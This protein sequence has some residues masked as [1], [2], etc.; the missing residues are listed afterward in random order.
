MILKRMSAI[1]VSLA[2]VM[3]AVN[4]GSFSVA[5]TAAGTQAVFFVAPDG[6]DSGDGT[7]EAPFATLEKAR[8]EVRKING[9]MTGD[10]VVYLRGGDYR[11]TQPVE[12]DT[13]DSGTG[14]FNVRYEAYDKEVPV[15]NG[16]QQVTG[17]TKYNDKLWS[18]PLDRDIKLRNLYVNDRRANMGSVQVQAK[19]GYGDYHVTAGQ[20]DWAWD[21]GKKSDGIVYD[22]GSMPRITSN[23]DDLEV[24]NGTTWNENI[25]CSRD[26]KYDGG[27]MILLM[28][29]PYGAIAQTPGWGAGFSTGG[30]HTIY[31]AFSFVDSEGEFFFDKTQK[32]LY[33]YPRS[34]EDMTSADVEAPVADGLIKIAGKST[35]DR[36]QN[37]SFSGITFANTDYQL[38][39]VA[40]SHGKTTCQAAQSY[41][42]FADS[43]WHSKKYEMVDT[44][45]AAIHIT[46]SDNIK[47]TGNVVK[48][49]GADGIS[50]T[51]DV[52]NSEV[53]GNFITDITSSGITVGHPQHIYIGDAAWNNH[54]KFPKEVEGICK[55]DLITQN[56]LYDISVV[57]GFGGCAA[58]TAY[59]VESVKILSNT[60]EKT[61]YNGIHLGW[62]WC[63]FKDSTTC[64]DNMICY[65]RV[66]NSLNRL[67]DSGGIYTIGQMPGTVINEN[68]IQG[69][70]AGGPGAPTYGLH[71][72]EGTTYIEENDNVLEIS[73]NVTYTINC[74]EY[75]D[76]HHLTIK[77]T[78][79]TVNKMG[80]NPPY[81]DIDIPIVVSDNV[82]PFAQ[83]KVC[84]NSGISDEYRSLMPTWLKSEADYAFPAS[85]ATTGGSKLPVRKVDGN[86]WI[87]P[88]G[89]TS[90]KAGADMTRA[91]GSAGSIRTPSEEGEYRIY[92][93]DREGK[94]LSKSSHILRIKG[95]GGN[96][97][98]VIEAENYD[99]KSG[100]DIENCSEGGSDVGYIE[101]GDYIGFKDID[102]T[103]ADKIDF[104][105]ASNG[106]DA[107]LEVRLDSPDGKLIGSTEITNTG[108][109]QEWITKTCN[110]EATSGKHDVYLVFTGGESYLFNINWWKPNTPAEEYI[111]GDLN[112]DGIVDIFDLC[113]MRNAAVDGDA[114][115]FEAADINGD[116][117]IDEN[118]LVLLKKFISGEIKAFV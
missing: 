49:T 111:L 29:Q 72:D 42:A 3:S 35:S 110:I 19:G 99:Y 37:I 105:V 104:R 58:I 15:I 65:N 117:V 16:A 38:T 12:F 87:A 75:G 101:N 62:G 81:S 51:N 85:C 60:I 74:E 27:S 96:D 8:D 71:N 54:E 31:N 53:S 113:S 48:H 86:I 18:A 36:V 92:V 67:H 44:L 11:L 68:Y 9:D 4:V 106:S 34:G 22:A 28:Q 114:E 32:V 14:G 78:Y 56:L 90:F 25:V 102:L 50:M 98:N 103:G 116:S 1:A 112:G 63:N 46:N 39:E 66:I 88:D 33:Y 83:Y 20:G 115:R 23:F 21:S 109:W 10:I 84:V 118:D 108:G 107:V 94:V 69:I 79:A 7:I 55:N 5:S 80:K 61:A 24:V 13:R 52:I 91:G 40:G 95:M 26:I 59:F 76:K 45:P 6:S 47:L 57:H 82:W 41:T 100:I 77:R 64:H 17:W 30:T 2:A 70:P 73:P 93:L 97:S 89:T 43:N